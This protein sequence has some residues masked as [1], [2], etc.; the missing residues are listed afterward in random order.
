AEERLVERIT[1]DV[2]FVIELQV[3]LQIGVPRSGKDRGI[4]SIGLWFDDGRGGNALEI[5]CFHAVEA[6]ACADRFALVG[7][8]TCPIRSQ[9]RPRFLPETINI[10]IPVLAYNA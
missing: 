3:D 1:F 9:R 5:G 4:Q 7:A 6:Q 8:G 10:G 2:A